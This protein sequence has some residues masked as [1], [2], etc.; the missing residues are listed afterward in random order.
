MTALFECLKNL[1]KKDFRSSCCGKAELAVIDPAP[2]PTPPPVSVHVKTG[3]F[4]ISY[5]RSRKNFNDK[6]SSM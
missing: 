5:K 1:S 6:D 4:D 2:P 3:C